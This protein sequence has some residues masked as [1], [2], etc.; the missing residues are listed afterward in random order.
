MRK[1]IKTSLTKIIFTFILFYFGINTANAQNLSLVKDINTTGLSY[2][3]QMGGFYSFKDKTIFTAVDDINGYEYWITD[4]TDAG[5]MLLKDINPTGDAVGG[6]PNIAVLNNNFIFRARN[7]DAP[8]GNGAELWISDGTTNGT[9]MLKDIVPGPDGSG[10]RG[11]IYYSNRVFFAAT[12]DLGFLSLWATDGTESGTVNIKSGIN[13]SINQDFKIGTVCNGKLYFIAEDASSGFELWVSNGTANGTHIVKDIYPG[14]ISGMNGGSELYVYNGKIYFT[15]VD[16]NITGYE[17]WTSDGTENGTQLI[18][19]VESTIG[20]S[21]NPKEFTLM[22]NLLYFVANRIGFKQELWVTDGTSAGT[23][24]VANINPLNDDIIQDLTTY[25]SKLYFSCNNGLDGYEIWQSDGTDMGTVLFLDINPGGGTSDPNHL[26]VYHDKLYFTAYPTG[27]GTLNLY[28]TDNNPSNLQLISSNPEPAYFESNLKISN[29]SLYFN[30]KNSYSDDAVYK[31][32]TP[33]PQIVLTWTG[34]VSTDWFDKNNWSPIQVPTKDKDIIIPSGLSLYPVITINLAKCHKIEIQSGANFS[35]TGGTLNVYGE[36]IVPS[37]SEVILSGGTLNLFHGCVIPPGMHFNNLTL[38]S[39]SNSLVENTYE[40]SGQN[41]VSG[42]LKLKGSISGFD[43]AIPNINM[44]EDTRLNIQKYLIVDQ[45][46]IGINPILLPL[47]DNTKIPVVVLNGTTEQNIKFSNQVSS[48]ISGLRC[49]LKIQ[50]PLVKFVNTNRDVIVSNLLIDENFNL[51][52]NSLIIAGKILYKDNELT[53]KKITNTR[54]LSGRLSIYNDPSYCVDQDLQFI[55]IDKLRYLEFNGFSLSVNDTLVLLNHLIVDTLKVRG[56]FS[57]AGKDVTIGATTTGTGFLDCDLISAGIAE[58]TLSLLG[59]ITHPPYELVAENLNNLILNNP[60][61]VKLNNDFDL[62]YTHPSTGMM[63]LFGNAKLISGSFDMRKS[64]IFLVESLIS[65]SGNQ[66]RITETPGNTFR[67]SETITGI[68]AFS[69]SKDTTVVT[70]V[71]NL[72]I[73][74]LGFMITCTNPL[75]NIHIYRVPEQTSGIND[76]GSINR[77]YFVSNGSGGI[78]LNALIKLKYDDSELYINESDLAIYRR[79]MNDPAG[80]WQLIPSTVNTITN[81]VT[82]NVGLSQLDY[83]TS[84]P[85][86]FT[87]YTLASSAYPLRNV[88]AV[89]NQSIS[90]TSNVLVYPNPFS[91]NLNAQF[92]AEVEESATIQLMDLTGKGMHQEEVQ[93]AAG[94]NDINLCCMDQLPAGIYF[95]RITSFNTNR[96]VKVVKD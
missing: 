48:T 52:G 56:Y 7:G 55:N 36:M 38:T 49:N 5:T 65:N 83:S 24:I 8:D 19:D 66:G 96:I 31:Y 27:S 32:T 80:V 62:P 23:H 92:N 84:L 21:S 79:S 30:G 11:F 53:S 35:M 29:E 22:N 20:I 75:N 6:D 12:D 88:E 73:G 86:G 70:P 51:A 69:I 50:N 37:L 2:A 4:G 60:A 85:V 93:L 42:N 58:G 78:G 33:A 94:I 25:R 82:A 74:N 45:G 43:A 59:N 34:A 77:V 13:L 44:A 95:M 64:R 18:L 47:Q 41:I 54:P 67:N 17:L 26:I 15:A 91:N 68:D 39:L 90:N 81:T 3:G 63:E 71:S 46:Q 16:N 28:E 14:V 87:F 89:I 72:N 1:K 10:C 9:T 76:N 61:G 57:M 40:F